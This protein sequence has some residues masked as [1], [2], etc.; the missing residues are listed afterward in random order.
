M[1]KQKSM[2]DV[3]EKDKQHASDDE[4][5][6]SMAGRETKCSWHIKKQSEEKKP[7]VQ[8]NNHQCL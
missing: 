4:K 2:K 6:G 8:L 3:T 1:E 5:E 7:V